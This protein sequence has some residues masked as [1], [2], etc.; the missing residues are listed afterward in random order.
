MRVL[1]LEDDSVLAF[2]V[3]HTL[4]KE[5]YDVL[6]AKDLASA[7]KA[8]AEGSFDLALL[9]V[10]LPDGTGYE[11]AG[12]LRNRRS[13][14][15]IFLTACD[16]EVHVVQ[17]F[18]AGA[19]DYLTKP[20]RVRE[21]L[22]RIKA[23]LRRVGASPREEEVLVAGSLEIRPLSGKATKNG[24]DL[25]LSATEYRLLLTFMS[26]EGQILSRERL[27]DKASGMDG[28]FLDDN[29]LSVYIRRL[30][31]KIEADP[32]HPGLIRTARGRGYLFDSGSKEAL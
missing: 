23:V 6:W 31:E 5:G 13:T 30:R 16:E 9:D 20:F 25:A 3:Q 4:Q 7:R 17:G 2:S 29:S 10:R 12:E 11:L 27:L 21:L 14:G 8:L 32:A 22:S 28:V 24:K 1:L 19:D 18:D 26:H 15:V